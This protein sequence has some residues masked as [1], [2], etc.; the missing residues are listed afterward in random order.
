MNVEK[1]LISAKYFPIHFLGYFRAGM[2]G[3]TCSHATHKYL[4][5]GSC[6]VPVAYF[7]TLSQHTLLHLPK[8]LDLIAKFTM[9]SFAT[10]NICLMRNLDSSHF[11]FF[12]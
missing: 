8:Y 12:S 2:T 7:F 9:Q 10:L 6:L 4:V 3:G 1:S 5:T 11:F